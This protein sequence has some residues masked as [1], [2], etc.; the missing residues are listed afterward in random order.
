MVITEPLVGSTTKENSVMAYSD[1]I[2]CVKC[3]CKVVYYTGDH[4][5]KVLCSDCV[6]NKDKTIVQLMKTNV[7]LSKLL[8]QYTQVENKF[9]KIIIPIEQPL[10]A[11]E[12]WVDNQL[13][14][15]YYGQDAIDVEL[16]KIP[17]PKGAKLKIM[18][19]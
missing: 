19:F 15:V 1:Y 10:A 4:D 9:E 8:S 3:D 11:T 18:D 13:L 12:V 6:E 17:V 14:T 5:I 16:G 2:H 7:F